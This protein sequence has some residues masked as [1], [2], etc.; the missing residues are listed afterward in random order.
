MSKNV[1]IPYPVCTTSETKN[2]CNKDKLKS[3]INEETNKCTRFD[4]TGYSFF[5]ESHYSKV[6]DKCYLHPVTYDAYNMS[7]E[8]FTK[9]IDD[10][11]CLNKNTNQ[12]DVNQEWPNQSEKCSNNTEPK[13]CFK[14]SDCFDKFNKYCDAKSKKFISLFEKIDTLPPL[15]KDNNGKELPDSE[16]SIFRIDPV[17]Y[18]Y[19]IKL[20]EENGKTKYSNLKYPI[21]RAIWEDEDKYEKYSFYK[22]DPFIPPK[23]L[24][25]SDNFLKV[26]KINPKY[27]IFFFLIT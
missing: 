8:V 27:Y 16:Q 11:I 2:L 19:R 3:K 12:V 25:N 1:C 15:E 7:N 26:G 6:D 20:D 10:L 18:Q 13:K 24:Y 21:T 17:N 14:Q 22:E 9:D 5:N 23:E 4:P